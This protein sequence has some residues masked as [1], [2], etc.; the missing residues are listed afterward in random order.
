MEFSNGSAMGWQPN[1][2]GW[3]FGI[4]QTTGGLYI[5]Q[6]SSELGSTAS[7]ATYD[8]ILTDG[9]SVGIGTLTPDNKLTVNGAA[10]KPGGGSW[11]TFS[12]ERLKNVKGRF[13]PGIAA[14]MR[15]QPVR[16][17]YKSDN[18]L[19]INLPGEHV[20]FSAQEVEKII[21]EAVTKDQQGYRVVNN[22]PIIWTMLNAI[23]EQQSEIAGQQKQIATLLRANATLTSRV[24]G[25]ERYVPSSR[26]PTRRHH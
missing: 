17:E 12:D 18:A 3:H 21:P 20:G 11:G 10:D 4:G 13:T 6:S 24:R 16:Y 7:P 14:L 1:S 15:L 9:G 5:F 25:V 22:D 8:M 26:R 2:A 19:K 23:K